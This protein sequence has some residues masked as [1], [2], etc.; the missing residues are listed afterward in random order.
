LEYDDV[1]NSQREVVYKK[2]RHALFGERLSLDIS[3]MLYDVS[4]SICTNTQEQKDY[5]GFTVELI[6]TFS[7]ESPV[8]ESDF[9]K[10]PTNELAER[11]FDAAYAHYIKKSHDM[12]EATFPVVKNVYENSAHM[13]ENIIIPFTDGIKTLQ[14]LSNLKKSYESKG[15]EV[16]TAFE[17]GVTLSIIDEAWKD[18]LRA[19]DELKQSVQNAVYEQKDPLLVYKFESFGLFKNLMSEVNNDIISFLQKGYLSNENQQAVREV[20]AAPKTDLKNLQATKTEVTSSGREE[21]PNE[22]EKPKAQPIRVEKQVGRN[23]P[24]PC[25]NGKKFKHCHGK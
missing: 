17:K 16:F 9:M 25:G 24:C 15:R 22:Q 10:L 4:E 20:Q 2:R 7:I 23:D 5:E 8:S 1:M 12:G 14:V 13:Y 3:N 21:L 11:V 18:H 19:M 6:K